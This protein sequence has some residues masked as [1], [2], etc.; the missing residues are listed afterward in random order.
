MDRAIAFSKRYTWAKDKDD[1]KDMTKQ[2][3]LYYSVIFCL[4]SYCRYRKNVY[5]K[6]D[7]NY[8]YQY[9][10]DNKKEIMKSC[11][12]NMALK[13]AVLLL[14]LMPNLFSFIG[15]VVGI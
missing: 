14:L 5:S 3:I 15:S 4:S 1:I 12:I 13:I 6:N 7:V 10:K 9:L 8:I 2:I 11:K